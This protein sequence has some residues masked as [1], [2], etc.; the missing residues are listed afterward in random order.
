MLGF[1]VEGVRLVERL[2]PAFLARLTTFRW[3]LTLASCGPGVLIARG[4]TIVAPGSVELGSRVFIGARAI[5][6]AAGGLTIGDDV[7]IGSELNIQGGNHDLGRY[8]RDIGHRDE[9]N[10]PLTIG[11]GAW[12]GSRVTI[13]AGCDIGEYA[14]IAAGSVCS[15][16]V[17][18][19][20]MV[21]G[22]PARVIRELEH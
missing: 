1:A 9:K 8:R 6:S 15:K 14:V 22:V 5:I 3:R 20:T 16:P 18:P 11:E 13:L 12:I 21:G 19:W 4:A 10:P 7:M 2:I 17:A